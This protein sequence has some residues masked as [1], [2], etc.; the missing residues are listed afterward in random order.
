MGQVSADLAGM[1]RA[2]Q[3]RGP[4]HRATFVDGPISLGHAR[5]S[6]ID[7][8]AASDQ[9]FIDPKSGCVII[10]N[11]ETYNFR[12][13]RESLQR[14]GRSFATAGDTEVLLQG[15]LE[16][17]S[18]FFSRLNGIFA[19]AIWDPRRRRLVLARDPVGVKPMYVWQGVA[20]FAF[21]SEAK[22]LY[23]LLDQFQLNPVALASYLR[24]HYCLGEPTIVQGIQ[25]FPAGQVWELDDTGRATSV[26]AIPAFNGAVQSGASPTAVWAT[27]VEAV[28]RQMVADVPVGVFLS[29]GIDSSVIAT[30]AAQTNPSLQTFSVGFD[31]GVTDERPLA[32]ELAAA[33]G[34]THH[35]IEVRGRTVAKDLGT[36]AWHYDGPLGEGGCIPNWY[37]SQLAARHVKVVLAGEGGDEVFGG[38]PWYLQFERSEQAGR[39][40]PKNDFLARAAERLPGTLGAASAVLMRKGKWNRYAK[41]VESNSPEAL[42]RA[43]MNPPGLGNFPAQAT[44]L[45]VDQATLLRDC[46]LVKADKMTMAHGLEERVPFLDM[47]LLA[48]AQSIPLAQRLGPPEKKILREAAA[49]HLPAAVASRKKQG[50]GTPMASWTR[51]ALADQMSAAM[52]SP[53]AVG[54]GLIQAE[55]WAAL[56]KQAAPQPGGMPAW[57]LMALDVWCHELSTRGVFKHSPPIPYTI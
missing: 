53:A 33:L 30:L 6:I 46:F 56:A 37:V 50:Y 1:L 16:H 9:P 7:L 2:V 35:Q 3:H 29:G 36:L 40:L 27:V 57:L 44:M 51:G 31:E 41:F 48:F 43:G 24:F 17:G 5:L 19:L 39:W 55:T 23:P 4:D 26:Q 22:A 12:E 18:A 8:S 11:G 25:R 49:P 14:E 47:E 13:L 32:A 28:Q 45:Q 54:L 52:D 21:A 20:G 15:Y 42:H 38:Y 34:S 10:Y